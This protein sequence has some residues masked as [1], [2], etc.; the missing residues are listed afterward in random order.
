MMDG[1]VEPFA[2][3]LGDVC[4]PAALRAAEHGGAWDALWQPIVNSGFLDALVPEEVG[5]AGLTLAEAAP[6]LALLGRH[7]VPLPVADTMVAR[8]L[9]ARAGQPTPEGPVTIATGSGPASEVGKAQYRLLGT[10]AHPVLHP[11]DAPAGNVGHAGLRA[12]AAVVRAQLIAGACERVLE[13]TIAYA[14]DRVQFGKPI[15]RQQAVQQ[16]LA[17]MAEQCVAARIAAAV[18][19]RGGLGEGATYEVDAAIAKHGTSVAAAEICAISHGIF[20]AIGIS[21]EHD[22][23]LLTRLLHRWRLVDGGPAFWAQH[24]AVARVRCADEPSAAWV[25]ARS[26]DVVTGGI[27]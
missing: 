16:Q 10:A 3:L 22:L 6:L 27:A 1:L 25:A 20:G 15:G 18:G 12:I 8:A 9:L 2:R 13:M 7:A 19:A 23:Q 24:L 11:L 21:E 14:T 17:I 4:T 5:G 26:I